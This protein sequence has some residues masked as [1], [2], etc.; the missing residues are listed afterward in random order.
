MPLA[1]GDRIPQTTVMTMEANGPKALST[2]KLFGGRRVAVF[3]VPGAYTPVCS[4]QHLPGYVTKASDLSSKGIDAIACVSI[5]DPFVL[6]AWG[7]E[8]DAGE[9]MMVADPG[10]DFTRSLGLIVDLSDF[11]LGERSERYS[12]IVND[13]VIEVLNV[14]GSILDHDV[15]SCD[16]LVS[17]A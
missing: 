7:K 16:V 17:Q 14:E 1:T 15:S 9:I 10:G 2:Y 12:M 6:D 11:G 5:N 13:G 3:G 4:A 8:H